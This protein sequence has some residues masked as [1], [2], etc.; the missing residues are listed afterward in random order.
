MSEATPPQAV[1]S[2]TTTDPS[3]PLESPPPKVEEPKPPAAAPPPK[4]DEP[5][6]PKLAAW[7]RADLPSEVEAY[8]LETSLGMGHEAGCTCKG[9]KQATRARDL[10]WPRVSTVTTYRGKGARRTLYSGRR[11]AFVARLLR[12][13]AKGKC[14]WCHSTLRIWTRRWILQR[15]KG[16]GSP[17]AMWHL[18][19]YLLHMDRILQLARKG[20]PSSRIQ[21]LYEKGFAK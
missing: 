21:D 1:P 8:L 19:C 4:R 6:P 20:A 18:R 11:F 2:P 15:E 12:A 17:L 16:T 10:L 7:D 3:P 5:T 9:C 13:P 14:R